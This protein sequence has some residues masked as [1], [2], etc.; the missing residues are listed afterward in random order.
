MFDALIISLRI[1]ICQVIISASNV[2]NKYEIKIEG[3]C[4]NKGCID[5]GETQYYCFGIEEK[6][7][8]KLKCLACKKD[9]T[10]LKIKMVTVSENVIIKTAVYKSK[11]KLD[12]AIVG[13]K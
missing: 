2:L 8:Y 13:I 6:P 11:E 9:M 1:D 5:K 4:N 7:A 3:Q 10:I 12:S